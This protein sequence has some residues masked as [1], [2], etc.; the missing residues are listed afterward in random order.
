GARGFW[1]RCVTALAVA[2]LGVIAVLI[3]LRPLTT[4]PAHGQAAN[5]NVI[6]LVFTFGSEKLDWIKWATDGVEKDGKGKE[7]ITNESAFNLA[8][9]KTSSGKVIQVKA[10][11][12]GS[13]ELVEDV[14]EGRPA[15]AAVKSPAHLISPASSAYLEIGNAT[16]K[17][18]GKGP[19][20]ADSK[21][22]V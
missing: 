16:A 9:R 6:E 19:V 22:L 7:V 1:T 11:A 2:S 13:G 21:R 10:I 12:V 5:A 18:R 8:K 17:K 14:L 15:A 20:V 4:E 3:A